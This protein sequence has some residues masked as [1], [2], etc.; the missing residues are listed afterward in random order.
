MHDPGG[1]ATLLLGLA[2]LDGAIIG[3]TLAADCRVSVA[4]GIHD[5]KLVEFDDD[6]LS[7]QIIFTKWVG[8]FLTVFC[9]H[10]MTHL[11]KDAQQLVYAINLRYQMGMLG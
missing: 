9:S 10:K 5:S 8:V 7:E 4:V 11:N 1:F 6:S 2:L 3:A